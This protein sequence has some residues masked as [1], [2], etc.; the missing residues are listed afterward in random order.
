MCQNPWE[1]IQKLSNEF[2]GSRKCG[3][4]EFNWHYP[5]LF[6]VVE[7]VFGLEPSNSNCRVAESTTHGGT[8]RQS[9]PLCYIAFD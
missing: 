3:L 5:V 4:Q 7:C 9:T 8:V 2:P 1:E 6:D